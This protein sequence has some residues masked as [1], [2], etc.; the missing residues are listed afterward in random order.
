MRSKLNEKDMISVDAKYTGF[1]D[2]DFEFCPT[3]YKE[4][5]LKEICNKDKIHRIQIEVNISKPGQNKLIDL[6]VLKDGKYRVSRR[7][8][9]KKIM[10]GD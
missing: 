3:N 2:K 10:I 5:Y 7:D 4:E 6:A 1:E 9:F 8:L